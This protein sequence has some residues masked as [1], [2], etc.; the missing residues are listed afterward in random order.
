M[1][2]ANLKIL[3]KHNSGGKRD[4]GRPQKRWKDQF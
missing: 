1:S 4:P 2:L 3:M